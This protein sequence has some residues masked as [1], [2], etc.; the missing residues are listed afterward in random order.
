[1]ILTF[2]ISVSVR[3]SGITVEH[4]ATF[5]DINRGFSIDITERFMCYKFQSDFINV[6]QTVI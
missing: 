4:I 3:V 5:Y 1:M 2:R 6:I